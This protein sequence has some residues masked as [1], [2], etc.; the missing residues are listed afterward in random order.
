MGSPNNDQLRDII[1]KVN[2]YLDNELPTEAQSQL[3]KDIHANPSYNQ[4]LEKEKDFRKFL[5]SNISK[6]KPSDQLLKSLQA[7]IKAKIS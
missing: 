3:F 6:Q 2:L 7:K 1:Q 5:K 4:I